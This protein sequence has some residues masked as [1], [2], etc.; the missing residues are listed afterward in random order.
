MQAVSMVRP[1]TGIRMRTAC[2]ILTNNPDIRIGELAEK[3]GFSNPRY[4]STCF[5]NEYGMT[6]TEWINK[7]KKENKNDNI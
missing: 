6:P 1:A 4:F 7:D 2:Q 5:K 3:V